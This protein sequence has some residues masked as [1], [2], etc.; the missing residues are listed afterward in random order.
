M[1][2][3]VEMA[4]AK[5]GITV[6]QGVLAG[7][8]GVAVCVAIWL[9]LGKNPDAVDTSAKVERGANASTE[10]NPDFLMM[11]EHLKKEGKK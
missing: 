9:T 4:Q 3:P 2:H 10:P 7:V 1:G 6:S 11:Q 5:K 8:V